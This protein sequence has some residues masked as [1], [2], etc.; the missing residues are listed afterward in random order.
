MGAIQGSE[1]KREW[2]EWSTNVELE[3]LRPF[4]DRIVPLIDGGFSSPQVQQ[5]IDLANGMPV[6]Q[7]KSLKF[8]IVTEGRKSTLGV[9]LFMD[10]I[11]SPDIYLTAE[12]SLCGRIS[13]ALEE[14][15]SDL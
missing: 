6:G 7:E 11:G 15:M 13:A 9:R 1:R 8:P 12:S 3:L 5:V 10:D 2:E 4:L 14:F